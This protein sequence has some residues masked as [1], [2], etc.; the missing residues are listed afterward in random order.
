[1]SRPFD[2]VAHAGAASSFCEFFRLELYRAGALPT[3][4]SLRI[5]DHVQLANDWDA[6]SFAFHVG[7]DV[8][9]VQIVRAADA[10]FPSLMSL[11][12]LPGRATGQYICKIVGCRGYVEIALSC[13]DEYMRHELRAG[14]SP[15]SWCG[16]LTRLLF[17]A[18]FIFLVYVMLR[19]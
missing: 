1:M 15:G 10:V 12:M 14:S 2:K 16:L 19:S 8:D 17:V 5:G 11:S 18:A 13:A 6:I 7:P 4:E 3:L 9:H